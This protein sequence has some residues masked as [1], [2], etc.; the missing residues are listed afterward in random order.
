MTDT[1]SNKFMQRL[2]EKRAE[3]AARTATMSDLYA[4]CIPDIEIESAGLSNTEIAL[5]EFMRL[6]PITE[7]YQRWGGQSAI[8]SIKK[9]V[10]VRCPNPQHS[11][12]DPSFVMNTEKNV[13]NCFKCGGGD[14]YDIAAWHKGFPVP[15]YKD[16]AYFR[17]LK[18][19][20][21]ADYGMQIHRDLSGDETLYKAE[22]PPETHTSAPLHPA[23]VTS[24]E[25]TEQAEVASV[26]YTPLGAAF[27]EPSLEAKI[28]ASRQHSSIDWRSI[29]PSGTFMR[30]YLEATTTDTC[31][32]EY[33]FWSALIALGLAAGRNRVLREE[34]DV[35]GNLFVCYTGPTGT[36][37]SKA[38]DHL[39]R[40]IENNIRFEKDD[41]IPLGT[42]ISSN[43]SSGEI[44]VKTFQHE[45]V[46]LATGKGTGQFLP[47][48]VLIDSEEL[49]GI[50]IRSARQGNTLKDML[51]DIYGAKT[52]LES[53]SLAN[54]LTA[55]M[56]FGSVMT[57]TQNLSIR[58]V[59]QKKDS[60]S[61][62]V[63]R[64]VFA[65]GVPKKEVSINFHKVD[66]TRAGGLIRLINGECSSFEY[67]IWSQEAFTVFDEFFHS[68]VVKDKNREDTSITQRLDLLLKKL[69]LL[70]TINNRE[71]QVTADTVARVLE[72]YPYLLESY[73]VI[74]EQVQATSEG[75]DQDYIMSVVSRLVEKGKAPSARDVF[76]LAKRRVPNTGAVVKILQNFVTL[77]MLEE[78]KK[79]ST[80]KG[81][82][83]STVYVPAGMSQ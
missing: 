22:L 72:I 69:C 26:S 75:D 59:L 28:L 51:M 11:D 36:G 31:P 3:E 70:F 64:W 61:G 9:E 44:I 60:S 16:K 32:E 46:D 27:A 79:P 19:S 12:K 49:A 25:V 78:F 83:P 52:T 8:N 23:S 4:D 18:D 63:N 39:K 65:T 15:G 29:V 71:K 56:P 53:H 47:V 5:D 17:D 62:F 50:A 38:K 42:K 80:G 76:Q 14:I 1:V 21:A 66:L 55:I 67:V 2:N 10:K 37:K 6:I 43:M 81:G 68:T 35:F 41:A 73:D 33:H 7:A 30:A 20:I 13:F 45:L 58:E 24:A 34:P 77:G 48:R 74:D 40:L 82:R 57:T 54:D